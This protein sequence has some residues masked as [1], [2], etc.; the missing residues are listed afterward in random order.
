MQVFIFFIII[1]NEK[2]RKKSL[3][4]H[5]EVNVR[6]VEWLVSELWNEVSCGRITFF[7]LFSVFE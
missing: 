3:Q 6:N 4:K 5:M 1:I 7:P 2:K